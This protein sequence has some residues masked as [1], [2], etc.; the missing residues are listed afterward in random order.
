V[1]REVAVGDVRRSMLLVKRGHGV[2]FHASRSANRASIAA[3][4][5]DWRRMGATTGIAG[6]REHEWH[7]VFLCADLEGAL[8][9]ASMPRAGPADVWSVRVDGFWLEGAP[10]A[11]GGGS[12]DWMIAPQPIGPE[13]VRLVERD[14][15]GR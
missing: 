8:W 3:H 1:E 2:M 11:N 15:T 14:I 12:D 5:L 7:G 4:G 9:F 6:S 10:D 13:R